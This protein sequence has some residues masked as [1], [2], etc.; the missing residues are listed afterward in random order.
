MAA[1]FARIFSLSL[2]CGAVI[3][4]L[5]LLTPLLSRRFS[6]RW[7]YWAWLMVALRLVLP[8]DLSL[9]QAPVELSPPAALTAPAY[10][11]MAGDEA[12]ALPSGYQA[13]MF[14]QTTYE[15][16]Y[17]DQEQVEHH[18]Y[19]F[20]LLR[21]EGTDGDWAL[22]FRWEGLWAVGAAVSLVWLG[23][24]YALLCRRFRRLRRPAPSQALACLGVQKEA[25]GLSRRVELYQVPGLSSPLL[26]GFFR[27]VILLPEELGEEALPV[28][29]AHELTHLKRHDLWYKLLLSLARCLHWFNPLVWLMAARAGRDVELCC[30]WDLLQ[31][32]DEEARRAYGQAILDQMV[33]GSRHTARLTTGFSGNKEEVF[34]RFRAMMDLSPRRRGRWALVL[35][36]AAVVVSGALVSCRQ[37]QPSSGNGD[38]WITALDPEAGTLSY[39]PLTPEQAQDAAG[40]FD[41]LTKGQLWDQERTVSLAS[42]ALLLHTWEGEAYALNPATILYTVSM[43]QQGVLGRVELDGDGLAAQVRL[44]DSARL[45]LAGADLDFTGYCGTVY[46]VGTGAHPLSGVAALDIDPCLADGQDEDHTR[47]TLPLAPAEEDGDLPALVTQSVSP[48]LWELTVVDGAVTAAKILWTPDGPTT[49]LASFFSAFLVGDRGSMSRY[50]TEDCMAACETG[51]GLQVFGFTSLEVQGYQPAPETLFLPRNEYAIQVSCRGL[52]APDSALYEGEGVAVTGSFYAV[53]I[54]SDGDWLVDR[55]ITG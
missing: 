29:L 10:D 3:A 6:P 47:Y 26:M 46:A 19:D 22:L 2:T 31:G 12:A 35:A 1:L 7:R 33:R 30:D 52:P 32:R 38:A 24:D 17:T 41:L 11:G 51:D 55:F 27:P 54:S 39:I 21:L 15:V 40:V 42:G 48:S 14:T 49:A 18:I 20:G 23:A 43:S 36:L 8:L 4:L 50:A 44:A 9:P 25:L 53:L 28:T 37:D 45:D 5:L 34:A 16:W 13:G